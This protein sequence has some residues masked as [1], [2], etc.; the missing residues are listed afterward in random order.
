MEKQTLDV[1]QFK[2]K[3]LWGLGINDSD[4]MKWGSEGFYH[5]FAFC[6]YFCEDEKWAR[7]KKKVFE[8]QLWVEQEPTIPHAEIWN[9]IGVVYKS[10]EKTL[11]DFYREFNSFRKKVFKYIKEYPH[12]V[13]VTILN[14]Y[15]E[16]HAYRECFLSDKAIQEVV[17]TIEERANEDKKITA[18]PEVG[19]EKGFTKMVKIYNYLAGSITQEEMKNIPVK[20]KIMLLTKIHTAIHAVKQGPKKT[21]KI[22]RQLNVRKSGRQELE[23][24]MLMI[25]SEES[26]E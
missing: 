21:S 14:D 17:A 1:D 3:R 2:F 5:F 15:K 4:M 26:E 11:G 19:I 20:D 18:D 25:T 7:D 23:E 9:R 10:N 13:D 12:M 16:R 8:M 6:E 24:S 22:L